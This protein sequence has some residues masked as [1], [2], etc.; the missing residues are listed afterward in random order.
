M[1]PG[2]LSAWSSAQALK[3]ALNRGSR[4]GRSAYRF[5]RDWMGRRQL[6]ETG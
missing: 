1:D 3:W 4:N 2:S 6:G 5:A